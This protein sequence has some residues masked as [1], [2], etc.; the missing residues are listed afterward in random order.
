MKTKL[1]IAMHKIN[2]DWSLKIKKNINIESL[3][4]YLI[5]VEHFLKHQI[6]FWTESSVVSLITEEQNSG[7]S[8]S[9]HVDVSIAYVLYYLWRHVKKLEFL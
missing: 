6:R 3:L 8:L 1:S 7:K 4:Y 2:S 9:T 5:K